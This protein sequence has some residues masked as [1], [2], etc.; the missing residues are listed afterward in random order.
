[1]LVSP[2]VAV[3]LSI[4]LVAIGFTTLSHFSGHITTHNLGVVSPN[5]TPNPSTSGQCAGLWPRNVVEVDYLVV[6]GGIGGSQTL[7]DIATAIDLASKAPS[8]P[9]GKAKAP[10]PPPPAP[11][12][13]IALIEANGRLGGN[14]YDADVTLPAGY[15]PN[16]TTSPPLKFGLGAL[17]VNMLT[18]LN[19]RRLF[20]EYNIGLYFSPFRQE[21]FA[22]GRK[23]L[24]DEPGVHDVYTPICSKAPVFTDETQTDS[25]PYGSAFVGLKGLDDPSFDAWCY[26]TNSLNL[27]LAPGAVC[28]YGAFEVPR[29]PLLNKEC[30]KNLDGTPNTSPNADP[31]LKC[32]IEA[33]KDYPDWTSFL[34]GYFSEEYAFFLEYD[35]FGFHGEYAES[36]DA[37]AYLDWSIR[38]WNT[39][40]NMGYPIG[41]MSAM[42]IR[43]A[44]RA[45]NVGA[46]VYMNEAAMCIRTGHPG[47]K[48]EVKT[49]SHTFRVRNFMFLNLPPIALARVDGDIPQAL[50]AKPEAQFP[51]PTMAATFA[52]QWTP[53]TPAWFYPYIKATE[54]GSVNQWSLRQFGEGCFSRLE[55]VN[56]PYNRFHNTIRA[57]YS[58]SACQPM[59]IELIT[60]AEAKLQGGMS[61]LDAY[62]EVIER[63][64]LELKNNFPDATIPPPIW[65]KGAIL[66]HAWHYGRQQHD[67][68][69]MTNA[70]VFDFAKAPLGDQ[71][72]C[73]I[74]EAYNMRF[75]GWSEG[76]LISSRNCITSRFNSSTLGASLRNIYSTRDAIIAD[77]FDTLT[78]C[79]S[80]LSNEYCGPYGPF[81]A[82]GTLHQPFCVGNMGTDNTVCKNWV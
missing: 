62:S 27:E 28:N 15:V 12:A 31:N 35:N 9:A 41:G 3:V 20:N 23:Q 46:N 42:A 16:N 8:P 33:C 66:E 53:N 55:V 34:Q 39:A 59:W 49:A 30:N 72:L 73:L 74:G 77:D 60:N 19:E 48:Y 50:L 52:M 43:A 40:S 38:E 80:S 82:D 63:A 64:M 24:C 79:P 7:H 32:P 47:F 71:P 18:M 2:R 26:L 4:F 54:D 17:R 58:D 45:Q 56:V 65:V 69:N 44:E 22:R 68:H 70:K 29:H 11:K 25:T 76:A 61:L 10:P 78:A 67:A 37:C 5:T 36:V 13:T 21:M 14:F 75:S 1:M 57:V 81:Q 6:G 51:I